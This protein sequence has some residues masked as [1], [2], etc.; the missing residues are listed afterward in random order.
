MRIL[1]R[2]VDVELMVRVFY[3]R[4]RKAFGAQLWYEP[5][6]ER[7]LAAARPAC[8]SENLHHTHRL[9]HNT[10]SFT[11]AFVPCP[12]C[13]GALLPMTALMNSPLA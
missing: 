10:V 5:L 9:R 11:G 3:Q 2:L 7:R 6:D 8:E 1:A 12:D 13:Y 4:H